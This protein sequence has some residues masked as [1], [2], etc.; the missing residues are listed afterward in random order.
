M[1][2]RPA[3]ALD[4]TKLQPLY[5]PP[6]APTQNDHPPA[7]PDA[8]LPKAVPWSL[9]E[10]Q[11]HPRRLAVVHRAGPEVTI[12]ALTAALKAKQQVEAAGGYYHLIFSVHPQMS[13]AATLPQSSAAALELLRA[14]IGEDCVT[15]IGMNDVSSVFSA[16]LMNEQMVVMGKAGDL[17][18]SWDKATDDVVDAAW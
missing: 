7:G 10:Q 6:T 3:A 8:P 11:L 15:P 18:V 5:P 4:R 17:A 12:P 1:P 2:K 16:A 13:H 14:T 9:A